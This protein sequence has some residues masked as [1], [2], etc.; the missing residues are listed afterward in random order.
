M[1]VHL[2]FDIQHRGVPTRPTDMGAS[3]DLDTDG[4]RGERGEREV[5]LTEAYTAAGEERCHEVG[6]GVTVIRT[7]S[8]ADRHREAIRIAKGIDGLVGYL[9]AHTNAGAG[10]YGLV[11]PDH[12]SPGG[13][14]LALAIARGLSALPELSRCRVDPLYPSIATAH[15]AGRKPHIRADGSEDWGWHTRG[16][17]CIS[18][19]YDGPANLSGVI[20]EPGFGDSPGHRSLWTPAGLVRVGRAIVDGARGVA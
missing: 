18:G 2:I 14:R 4:V 16:W 6:L 19:I 12:R 15:G 9:A 13:G 7:G 11:R 1:L 8:Y 20:V 17:I 5:D 3:Y 10:A